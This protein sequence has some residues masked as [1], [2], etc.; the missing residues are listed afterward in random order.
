MESCHHELAVLQSSWLLLER[1]TGYAN[2]LV[3]NEK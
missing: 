2:L 3:M 1:G